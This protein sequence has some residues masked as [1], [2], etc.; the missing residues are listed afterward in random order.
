MF[1][2]VYDEAAIIF[3]YPH[4]FIIVTFAW[5]SWPLMYLLRFDNDIAY[6]TFMSILE[7]G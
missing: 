3:S 1:S 5:R 6:T 4:F 7:S 2:I